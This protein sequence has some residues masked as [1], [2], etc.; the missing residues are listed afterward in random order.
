MTATPDS[1]AADTAAVDPTSSRPAGS[2]T[3]RAWQ[4]TADVRAAVDRLP[5]LVELTDGT[6]DPAA[7]AHYLEQDAIYLAAYARALALI[8]ARAPDPSQAAF[9]ARAAAAA[10]VEE[11]VLHAD[12]LADADLGRGARERGGD[13]ASASPTTLGYAS[14]L[15][16]TAATEPYPVAV[17]AVLP[18]FWV[19]ADVGARLGAAATAD[20]AVPH[21]FR[22]WIAAYGDPEFA[23]GAR[24]ACEVTDACAPETGTA[25]E[26]AMLAAFVTATRFELEFWRA[27]HVQ[28]A[29]PAL[30][31]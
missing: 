31:A 28:E 22:A 2:F 16:A 11:G 18:C 14:W 12:L 20:S 6:L 21:P 5:F 30:D 9:W 27:A 3:A 26:A 1:T 10:A 19:Y 4:A 15:V 7:F 25:L 17:A 24:D 8:A 13:P 29:W 23:R